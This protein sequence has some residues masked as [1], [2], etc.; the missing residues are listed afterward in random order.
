[1]DFLEEQKEEVESLKAIFPYE[2]SE[3]SSFPPTFLIRIDELNISS[4]VTSLQLKISLPSKY[5]DEIPSIEIPNRSNALPKEFIEELISFLK[6]SCEESIGMPMVFGLVD[7]AKEWIGENAMKLNGFQEDQAAKVESDEETDDKDSFNLENLKDKLEIINA[8]GGRWDFVIGLIGKPSAG[9]ST[10]F[11][12]ATH[13]NMAKIGAHPF[14]TIEPNIGQA[15][16]AIP[17]P[18]AQWTKRCHAR[19]GHSAQCERFVPVVLKDV[20]GLVPGACEGRGRGNKFLNDLLD[21]DV[22]IHV[23]DL[24]GQ[25]DETGKPTTEYDLTRDVGWIQQELHS[26]IYDNIMDKWDSI[27]KKPAK[28]FDM[29]TG[30][31]AS[32]ALIHLTFESAGMSDKKLL[33]LP[34]MEKANAELLVHKLVDKFLFL[35]FP[36]LLALN[37]VDLPDAI[38]NLKKF[39]EQFV[40]VMMVPV[41]ARSECILQQACQDDLLSYQ[42][43]A[44]HFEINHQTQDLSEKSQKELLQ[45]KN[46]ILDIFGDT[47]VLKALSQAVKLRSPGYA[48]PVNCLDTCQS[49]S[50]VTKEKPQ[51]LR[52]CIVLKPGTT[53]EKLFNILLYPPV[54]L[55]AGEYVR[56]EGVNSK[57]V[58][59][60]L[61]K[62]DIVNE[63]N[64]I[65][66][67]MSTRKASLLIKTRK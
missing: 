43:G 53:V 12:A 47:G 3:L 35:R 25:T 40:D 26:W 60:V 15:F 59:F 27:V 11:N 46:S 24:S 50:V 34:K 44:S 63:T 33:A 62:H 18:C 30:Y 17:C 5:P 64:Q 38:H 28:L 52:D 66:K 51:V 31:H 55:L 48:F 14:T 10:F 2:F 54:A 41:S 29:F 58:K 20:A 42:S 22:L 67:I 37:K 45:V 9:K 8:K 49:I 16:Y 39:Q 1:M 4:S 19:Y 36:I 61:H 65:L 6:C 57:G 56:A 13:Q 7:S 21:A 23:I 32:Q